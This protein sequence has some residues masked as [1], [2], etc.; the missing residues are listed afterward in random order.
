MVE[1]PLPF[2]SPDGMLIETAGRDFIVLERRLAPVHKRQVFFHEVGHLICGHKATAT[3]PPVAAQLLPSLSPDLVARVLRRD[4]SQT[5]EEQEAEYAGSLIGRHVST[6][7]AHRTWDV[8]PGAQELAR[9]LSA[10]EHP[11]RLS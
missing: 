1:V 6:W 3:L 2:G 8:P 11:R 5:E 7:A 9:R 4:H 10:L